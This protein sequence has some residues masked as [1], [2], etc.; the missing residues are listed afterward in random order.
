MLL[1]I[2]QGCRWPRKWAPCMGALS[3][4]GWMWSGRGRHTLRCLAG[5]GCCTESRPELQTV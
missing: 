4:A 1:L 3:A 5:R 2:L